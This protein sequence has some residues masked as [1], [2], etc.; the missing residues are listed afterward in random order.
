[1]EDWK[2][3][4]T[5]QMMADAGIGWMKQQ[6]PWS[7]IEPKP[8]RY[9]D[10]KYNQNSWEKY[11]RIVALAE[12][13]GLR[14]IARLDNTPEWAGG[15]ANG[16]VSYPPTD[17]EAFANFVA[18][19][20]EHYR[21]R[22]Q[23][24]QIWNEPNLKAE[25]GNTIDPAGY[26]LLLRRAYVRAKQVDPNVV[27]LSAPL[28]QT[29]EQGDRGLDELDY[30]QRL[31]D[32]G[33]AGSYDVLFANGY[34]LSQPP[35]AEPGPQALNFRR[36][37]LV[38]D[39]MVRNGEA[40]RP[41]WLN[42]YGWN[43]APADQPPDKL[44]WGR[45]TDQQQARYTIDGI[46][47]AREHWPW[48]GVINIW[49]FRQVGDIARDDAQYY[50]GMVDFEFTPRPVYRELQRATAD[51]RLALP[52]QYG[53]LDPALVSRGQW[54]VVGDREAGTPAVRSD[55]PNDQ[56]TV[57]FRGTELDLTAERGPQ[58]GRLGVEIDNSTATV[59]QLPRDERGRRYI[60]FRADTTTVTNVAVVTGL[61]PL[62]PSRDH[63]AVLTVLPTPDGRASGAVTLTGIEVREERP[64]R[65]WTAVLVA[66]AV[67]FVLAIATV[68]R[69]L[70][71]LR[72]GRADA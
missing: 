39:V 12:K 42:E 17:P 50:F 55:R 13:Y 71:R 44:K 41:V 14:V 61:D 33:I 32:A 31:Y 48:L 28:A 70:A 51:L 46:R 43:A 8:G 40:A 21:G 72:R 18:T 64:T 52:G 6:F 22:V 63:T 16:D 2:R 62:G 23:Y 15:H 7:E 5:V 24:L 36:V 37:E 56:L 25:W 57:H 27:I 1:V 53:V 30:L 65:T 35:E 60:D 10:D 19:F 26:A 9:W 3:E 58:G 66:V 67:L 49:F 69:T 29:L 4:R 34:G 38:R 47:Y 68:A 59:E 11:D 45:V 20:V 54:S